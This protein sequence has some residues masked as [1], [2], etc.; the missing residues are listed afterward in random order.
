MNSQP[1]DV[2]FIANR[3]PDDYPLFAYYCFHIGS[4]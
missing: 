1:V 4:Q 2:G 3:N